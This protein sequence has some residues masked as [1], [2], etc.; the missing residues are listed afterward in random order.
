VHGDDK[1]LRF[2]WEIAPLQMVIVPVSDDAGLMKK[3]ESLKKKL[4]SIGSVEVDKSE[5]RAGEKFNH[6]EMKGVPVR[7][8]LGLKDLK[9]KKVT[10]FRRDLNKKE[11][12]SEGKLVGVI[13]KIAKESGDNLRKEAD[14]LFKGRIREA[15]NVK[16]MK[17]VLSE[18][19]I[20]RCG[21]C[22]VGKEGVRC[23]EIVEKDV[24]ELK[25]LFMLRER[26]R[27]WRI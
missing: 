18:G 19:G 9:K 14:K 6:W 8:D 10:I 7:I 23:A 2:P 26:I 13:K 21:F 27:K 15:K 16:E 11:V 20:A 24:K 22:S 25:K 4:E 5:K 1:G 3:A 12:V 17:K